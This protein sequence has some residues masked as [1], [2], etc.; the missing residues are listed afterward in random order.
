MI[1]TAYP[2]VGIVTPSYNYAAFVEEAIDSVL[3]QDYP[4][5]DYLIMD[6]G[7]TDRT[8]KILKG[9]GSRLR[10]VSH[11]D[12]GQADAINQGFRRTRGQIFAFLNAD[13]R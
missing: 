2:T 6:G 1:V 11:Q 13:D 4:H 7:S 8:V 12:L 5:I 3:S 9:Y 10:Y